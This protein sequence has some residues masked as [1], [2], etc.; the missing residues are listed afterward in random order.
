MLKI[1]ICQTRQ[2]AEELQKPIVGNFN[3]RKVHPPVRDNILST[4]LADIPLIS[5]FNEGIR[6][7]LHIIDIF[8]NC[9]WVISLK[10]KKCITNTKV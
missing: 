3:K 6:L 2:L 10:V 4:D 7:L 8:S 5:K 9:T 1:G